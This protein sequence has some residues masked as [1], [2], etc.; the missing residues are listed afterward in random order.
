MAISSAFERTLIYRIVSYR[1]R[2]QNDRTDTKTWRKVVDAGNAREAEKLLMS[3]AQP[4]LFVTLLFAVTYTLLSQQT[5]RVSRL[6][7]SRRS[8]LGSF[9]PFLANVNSRSRSLYAIA[10]P[11]VVCRLSV[12]FVHPTQPVEIFGNVSL[13]FGTLAIRWHS[14]KILQRS[15][16]LNPSVRGL[17]ARGV[18]NYSDFG[19]IKWTAIFLK[20]C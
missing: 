19:H 6:P 13:P 4:C 16:Q 15:S 14:V 20:R 18:A 2:R 7:R 12:T 3:A 8:L 17:N 11:S 9:Q 1:I 5:E 10:R